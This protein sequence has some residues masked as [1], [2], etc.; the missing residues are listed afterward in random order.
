MGGVNQEYHKGKPMDPGKG[1]CPYILIIDLLLLT[2]VSAEKVI[3]H[4]RKCLQMYFSLK[5]L[6][7][8][9]TASKS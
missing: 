7:Q 5:L 3:T 4:K 8:L 6:Q 1:N 9:V 2:T